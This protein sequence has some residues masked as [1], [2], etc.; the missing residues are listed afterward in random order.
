MLG[1]ASSV[2]L[3]TLLEATEQPEAVIPAWAAVHGVH[4]ALRYTALA[5][6]RFPYPNQARAL[7]CHVAVW[8]SG[9]HGDSACNSLRHPVHSCRCPV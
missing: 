7:Y 3:L 8:C 2:A 5:A 6:L 4:V 1:L 9:K